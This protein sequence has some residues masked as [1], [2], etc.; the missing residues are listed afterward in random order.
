MASPSSKGDKKLRMPPQTIETEQA[1]LGALMI[2]PEGMF[3]VS[4]IISQDA[5]YSEKHRIIYR[6]MIALY[7]KSEPIDI[8]SVRARLSDEGSLEQI[9]GVSYLAEL[10][11]EVPAASNALHC[12]NQVQKKFMLRSLI[13]AGEYVAEL[14]YDEAEE[15][16]ET[17]DKAE[18]KIYE[19]TSSPTRSS[20][21]KVTAY[22]LPQKRRVWN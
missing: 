1:L 20:I 3:E 13:D 10:A 9:G 11:S 17:L 21:W 4:D 6:A 5:F 18:K 14:G 19:V 8:E 7:G 16:D 12:A 22:S 15:L 2:R